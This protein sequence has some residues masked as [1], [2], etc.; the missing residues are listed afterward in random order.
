VTILTNQPWDSAWP[1]NVGLHLRERDPIQNWLPG[2]TAHPV[3]VGRSVHSPESARASS[4]I[5][6][7]LAGHVFPSASKPGKPP[8]G[9]AGLA[10]I[11]SAAPCPV[12]AIGGITV[13][14]VADVLRAGAHS[15]AVI[16][17]IAEAPDPYLAARSLRAAIDEALIIERKAPA[18]QP[19]DST[20]QDA[21]T[22]EI[23][24]NGKS[25]IVPE[26]STIH[27]FLASK[28]LAGAMAIVERNGEIVPR[29]DYATTCV[30]PGDTIEVVHA[31]GGG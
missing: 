10:H 27:D 16:G 21:T 2:H 22:F 31:V 6:Y 1:A 14:R 15:A 7:V 18:M 4:G 26:H 12:I 30:T 24:V 3:L 13:E 20:T 29:G 8:L 25:V 28:R 11:V 5:D 9:L 17:A 23:V 19:T